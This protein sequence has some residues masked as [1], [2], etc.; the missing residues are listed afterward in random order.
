MP[1]TLG[2]FTDENISACRYSNTYP[3]TK[4]HYLKC[5][6]HFSSAFVHSALESKPDDERINLGEELRELKMD[7]ILFGYFKRKLP[8]ANLA[9]H[10]D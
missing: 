3:H 1:Q 5:L 9:V 8:S 2:H 4:H 6:P 10:S 7:S